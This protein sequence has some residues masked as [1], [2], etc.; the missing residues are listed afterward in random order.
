MYAVMTL[1]VDRRTRAV[2]RSPELG[3]LG[4]VM[5]TLMHTPLSAGALIAD[6]AGETACRARCGLRQPCKSIA[7]QNCGP[8]P[9]PPSAGFFSFAS[10]IHSFI[11]EFG[12]A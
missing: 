5:P 4:F 2:L 9:F 6:S 1:P 8:F 11:R 3:F 12:R 7:R 10:C